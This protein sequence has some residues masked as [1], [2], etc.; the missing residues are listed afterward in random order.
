MLKISDLLH[1][2]RKVVMEEPYRIQNQE[3]SWFLSVLPEK[4]FENPVN[5][6]QTGSQQLNNL[7]Y[8]SLCQRM[9]EPVKI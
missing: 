5:T 2:K 1:H 7:S 3:S 4:H 8:C 6:Q 9:L